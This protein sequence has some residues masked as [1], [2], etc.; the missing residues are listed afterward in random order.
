M[1]IPPTVRVIGAGAMGRGIAQTAAVAG[2]RVELTDIDAETSRQALAAIERDL[3]AAMEKG[4]VRP[5]DAAAACARIDPRPEPTGRNA[6]VSI[7]V[8]AI[9]E[10]AGAKISLLK[11]LEVATPNAVLATNT[12]A[13]SI[14]GLARDLKRPENL[15]GIHFFNPV[16][17]MKVAEVV[18]SVF[19]APDVIREATE[20]V[21]TLG[22][23]PLP[24]RD[25]PGFVINFLGRGLLTEALAVLAHSATGVPEVDAIARDVLGLRMGP[26]E[27]MDLTGLDISHGVMEN[28]WNG[29]Y[30]DPRLRP[31]PIAAARVT[32]GVLG[33]KTG[34]GFYTYPRIDVRPEPVQTGPVGVDLNFH[35]SEEWMSSDPIL[36]KVRTVEEVTPDAV[37]IV[38]PVGEPAY[39]AALRANLPVERTLGIDPLSM[40]TGKR[41]AVSAPLPMSAPVRAAAASALE[42]TGLPVTMV[43]DGPAP[44]AQRLLAS[45]VNVASILAASGTGEPTD[46]DRGARLGLGYPSG[47]FELADSH[48]LPTILRILDGL[49]EYTHDPRYQATPWLRTRADLGVPC[50]GRG[51]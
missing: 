36:S 26:F 20:F 19:T 6:D 11:D 39:R 2:Y 7:V 1:P 35:L 30:A 44:V 51:C 5:E 13:L 25:S 33:R 28:V 47:P 17:R 24:V 9:I 15:V 23:E 32:A 46:I 48:G 31:S 18:P 38:C 22:H 50:V 21:R 42:A 3:D 41:L 12:S 27:L 34:V 29:Y 37:H 49:F 43:P 8:E 16:P 4:R 10:D 14:A 40:R 45:M